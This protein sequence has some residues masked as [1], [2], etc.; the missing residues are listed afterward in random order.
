[1]GTNC[2]FINN[3]THVYYVCIWRPIESKKH[4][5]R[6]ITISAPESCRKKRQNKIH[7][8]RKRNAT[9]TQR[10]NVTINISCNSNYFAQE[11]KRILNCFKSWAQMVI[12]L[13][14][15]FQKGVKSVIVHGEVWEGDKTLYS[16]RAKEG[17]Q[18]FDSSYD[19]LRKFNFPVS[20]HSRQRMLLC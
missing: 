7:R 17:R 10:D 6:H 8:R 18:H 12:F 14:V 4:W 19:A 20:Q 2:H 5:A 15:C 11:D 9:I 16:H 3:I 1:M 13:F